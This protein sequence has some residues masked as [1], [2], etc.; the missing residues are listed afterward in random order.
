[1]AD[2]KGR[3]IE[4]SSNG[5]STPGYLVLPE[6][7]GPFPGV[8]AIQEWWGLNAHMQAIAERLAGAGFVALVPDLY[9][10]QIAE[11]PDEARKLA[12]ALNR[13]KAIQE[14][15][16][17]GRYLTGLDEV[18]P[19][20]V[21]LVGWCMGGGLSLSTAAHNGVVGAA[22]CFY[23]RPLEASDTARLSVPVLGLYGE[24]DA[25]IPASIV[26]DFEKE[27]EKNGVTHDIHMYAGAQHAFFNNTRPK[28]YHA[29]AA[30]DA[31][32]RT[33]TWFRT[34]LTA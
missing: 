17:A 27:L 20:Q 18:A 1:M 26:H 14:I 8:V 29:E 34:H 25:G 28:S 11:E 5:G 3:M 31:W 32:E 24:L 15:S 21:G 22:V 33:M 4:Y 6:G 9:H 16:A 30:E 7:D 19:K 2:D 10:G 13:E 23:G 12:M